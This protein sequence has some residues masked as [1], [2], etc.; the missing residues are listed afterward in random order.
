MKD[1]SNINIQDLSPD[2]GT[3]QSPDFYEDFRAKLNAVE[4]FPS[5]YTFKFIVKTELNKL[6]Q[7][8]SIFDHAS[9]K[10][11]EKDSS[12]G[13]YKSVTVETYVADADAVINYYKEVAKVESVI[14]L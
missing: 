12:G 5:L 7:V 2:G 8:K 10:F 4:Q 11:T 9:T 14:M 6:D 1:F 3:N 13:K